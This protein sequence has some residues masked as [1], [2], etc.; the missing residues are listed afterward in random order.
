M[1]FDYYADEENPY[2]EQRSRARVIFDHKKGLYVCSPSAQ[3]LATKEGTFELLELFHNDNFSKM[4]KNFKAK[5][6]FV[7]VIEFSMKDVYLHKRYIEREDPLSAGFYIL[8]SEYGSVNLEPFNMSREEE[9]LS[10]GINVEGMISDMSGFF[11][12]RKVYKDNNIIHKRGCL[13]YGPPGNGKTFSITKVAQEAIK[14]F[15]CVVFL[16]SEGIRLSN[17]AGYKSHL[18]GR[19]VM[20][21]VEEITNTLRGGKAQEELLS[22]LDGQTSWN[23]SYVISTTNNPEELP[24]NIVDRPGRFDILVEVG[25]P[26]ESIR[27]KYISH[28]LGEDAVTEDLIRGT[29]DLSVSYLKELVIQSLTSERDIID[30]VKEFKDTKKKI[31]SSFKTFKEG[32]GNYA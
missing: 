18:E 16:V 3:V 29:T 27:R 23:H 12:N 5:T 26:E 31:G 11:D 6:D 15:D 13:L 10:L 17:M 8:R 25:N 19:N 9:Y 21:I 24:A 14:K 32:T 7:D 30:I 4:F 28:F 2:P 1:S 20:F 22:F